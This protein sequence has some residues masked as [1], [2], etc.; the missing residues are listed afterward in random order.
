MCSLQ[1]PEG[2][3]A[4]WDSQYKDWYYVD[5]WTGRSQW[6]RPDLLSPERGDHN[7]RNRV[8]SG[9][10]PAAWCEFE[11]DSL[12]ETHPDYLCGTCR[13]LDLEHIFLRASHRRTTSPS[14]YIS[15]D[16]FRWMAQQKTC[17]LGLIVVATIRDRTKLSTKHA[18]FKLDADVEDLLNDYWYLSPRM[19]EHE[20]KPPTYNLLL[21]H[22]KRGR[23]ARPQEDTPFA[24]GLVINT[25]RGDRHIPEETLDFAWIQATMSLCDIS[26]KMS[27]RDFDYEILVVDVEDMCLV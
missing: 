1:V 13:Q 4:E 7:S 18:G 10:G 8:Q 3:K 26:T 5:I 25:E 21:Q 24:I 16:P 9:S 12:T 19:Y 27:K 22:A 15:L 23:L 11:F 6:T 2:W 14:D 17:G 20:S